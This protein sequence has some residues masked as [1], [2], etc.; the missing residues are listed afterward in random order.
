[1]IVEE[2]NV[3]SIRGVMKAGFSKIGEGTKNRIGQY[4]T[5]K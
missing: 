3:A 4:I 1:M 5:N 2:S